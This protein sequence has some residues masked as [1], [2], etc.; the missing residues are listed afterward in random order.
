MGCP[1]FSLP[2]GPTQAGGSCPGAVGGQS[3]VP[4]EALIAGSDLVRR[5]TGRPVR[6]Q[7]A[8]CNYC[9]AEGG[10]YKTGQVQ[11]AQVMRYVWTKQSTMGGDATP[12][13]GF[14]PTE[15]QKA[16]IDAMIYAIDR[17]DYML[18]GGK[19]GKINYP[20]EEHPGRYFRWHDSG[21][22]FSAIHLRMMKAVCDALP[23]ITFWAPTRFWAAKG[24]IE[25]VSAIN[26][27]GARNFIIRPSA[28]HINEPP[29][30]I[31]LPG[32][33]RG[34]TAF[35]KTL[36]WAGE[37]EG[38]YDWDCQTYAVEGKE[39]SAKHTCRHAV[40][41]VTEQTGR[42]GCRACWRYGDELEINYTLH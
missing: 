7:Q 36:K 27:V 16:W 15:A 13:D 23:D 18:D 40:S 20:A 11:F 35:F 17:A 4:A 19:V 39:E 31:D 29:P 38:A 42:V 3:I 24:G 41:P 34:S 1:S 33:A 28:Y 26:S 12:G 2:A 21:D 10:Q 14:R 37:A 30:R 5:V 6:L 8:I 32:W 9:Y 22:I 25:A